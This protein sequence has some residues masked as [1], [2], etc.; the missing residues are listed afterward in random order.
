M[1]KESLIPHGVSRHL[2]IGGR[3]GGWNRDAASEEAEVVALQRSSQL[4]SCWTITKLKTNDH[5]NTRHSSRNGY[6][7]V[8]ICDMGGVFRNVPKMRS[9]SRIFTLI[10]LGS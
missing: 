6:D 3:F 4:Q 1:R 8:E 2:S 7:G 5:A 9:M 10:I